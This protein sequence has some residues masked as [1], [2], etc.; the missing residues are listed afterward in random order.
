MSIE[1][2]ND[3]SIL[4]NSHEQLLAEPPTLEEVNVI[5]HKMYEADSEYRRQPDTF[6]YHERLADI[7]YESR[8]IISNGLAFPEDTNVIIKTLQLLQY[9]LEKEESEDEF[10][11][12][13]EF[14]KVFINLL[15]ENEEVLKLYS[16]GENDDLAQEVFNLAGACLWSKNSEIGSFGADIIEA[17]L[18][19]GNPRSLYLTHSVIR[20]NGNGADFSRQSQDMIAEILANQE[21]SIKTLVSSD[22]YPER[23]LGIELCL[24]GLNFN[25]EGNGARIIDNLKYIKYLKLASLLRG[26]ED[27]VA[28]IIYNMTLH[29]VPDNYLDIASLLDENYPSTRGILEKFMKADETLDC[30]DEMQKCGFVSR[31]R[32]SENY[33]IN[34]LGLHAMAGYLK[35]WGLE[36][37]AGIYSDAWESGT[38]K[39]MLE[40]V[41]FD[42]LWNIRNLENKTPGIVSRLTELQ[43]IRHFSRY[44]FYLL[45]EQDS[46]RDN[47]DLPY[48]V[49]L[50]PESDHNGAFYTLESVLNSTY[51]SFLDNRKN[52]GGDF[53]IRIFEQGNKRDIARLVKKVT[54]RYG[55]M[56]FAIMGA[57]GSPYDMFFGNNIEGSVN[58]TDLHNIRPERHSFFTP[59]ATMVL[60]SCSTGKVGEILDESGISNIAEAY[61]K[62][63]GVKV[64]AP[65]QDTGLVSIEPVISSNGA[66]F[67]V[68]YDNAKTSLY[69]PEK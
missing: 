1:Q 8:E 27:E 31:C 47:S 39:E 19:N 35:S 53:L 17:S 2:F 32:T 44:P 67:S 21:K 9:P 37:Y 28:S 50:Y 43:G 13:S 40:E 36:K 60:V 14:Q 42:N 45:L 23:Q 11:K 20:Q 62:A 66:D 64:K 10:K 26:K 25:T 18:E 65:D 63:F 16:A 57:H 3:S 33:A 30:S 69:S 58:K 41:Y 29:R 59:D 48:G 51:D 38:S 6:N 52:P 34:N 22:D 12:S 61:S 46:I 56:S 4:S 49:I 24:A 55:P 7:M 54:D 68:Q 5:K 15:K